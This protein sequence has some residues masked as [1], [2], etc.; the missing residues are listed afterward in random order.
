MSA[1]C[2]VRHY[3]TDSSTEPTP[4]EGLPDSLSAELESLSAEQL[5][6]TIVHARELLQF[7][8]ETECPIE[9]EPGDDIRRVT[10]HDGYTEVAKTGEE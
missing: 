9:L 5:R 8:D 4:P 2:R 1:N 10:E 7:R 6:K 3:V